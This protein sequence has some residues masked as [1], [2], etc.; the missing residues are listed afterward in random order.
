MTKHGGTNCRPSLAAVPRLVAWLVLLGPATPAALEAQACLGFSGGGFLAGT[1]A[2][3]R[4]GSEQ[5]TGTGG[6]IGVDLGAVAARGRFVAF[7][8]TVEYD[9]EFEF[10]DVRGTVAL[11]LPIPLLSVCPVGIV[12]TGGILPRNF[13][14]IPD[15]NATVYGAGLAL[16]RRFGAPGSGLALI[17]SLIVS[18]ENYGV[19][20]LFDDIVER[21]REVSAVVRGGVT[22][23]IGRILVRPYVAFTTAED[24]YLIA[25]ALLGVTF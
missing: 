23:E 17:P 20:R 14:D 4:D 13:S 25:G 18:V 9:R 12:G 11:K 10:E 16:G 8:G 6:A 15:R 21:G 19:D 5:T 22:A 24:S 7:S 1:G 3:W 2:V